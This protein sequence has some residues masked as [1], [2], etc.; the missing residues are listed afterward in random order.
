MKTSILSL[1]LSVLFI[2]LQGQVSVKGILK[3]NTTGFKEGDTVEV[4]G[5]SNTFLPLETVEISPSYNGYYY[6]KNGEETSSIPVKHISI[7]DNKLD[8]WDRVWFLHRSSYFAKNGW[9]RKSRANYELTARQEIAELESQ[10]NLFKDRMVLD[11]LD[12]LVHRIHPK[13]LPKGV[14]R[15]PKMY[16]KIVDQTNLGVREDG[17]MI[18]SLDWLISYYTEEALVV[19]LSTMMSALVLDRTYP[20]SVA[21]SSHTSAELADQ[22][23]VIAKKYV[24]SQTWDSTSNDTLWFSRKISPA[25]TRATWSALAETEYRKAEKLSDRNIASG[26]ATD[27]VYFQKAK[28]ILGQHSDKAG[29][30]AALTYLE[31]ADETPVL[32]PLELPMEKGLI[33]IKLERWVDAMSAFEKYLQSL[34]LAN[35]N[36]EDIKWARKMI[37]RCRK[38]VEEEQG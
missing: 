9:Q 34:K 10:G 6:V 25:I 13:S 29:L 11:Y 1:I 3:K 37:F 12:N 4:V 30:L 27:E 23:R 28:A 7:L 22:V 18:G 2:H 35:G 24:F 8:F 20:S 5:A 14:E 19:G 15:H 33:L 21:N 32:L 38:M 16:L 36:E 31:K 26:M 17:S